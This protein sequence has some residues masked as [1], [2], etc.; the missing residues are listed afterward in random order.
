MEI[1]A[2]FLGPMSA[3]WKSSLEYPRP[4]KTHRDTLSPGI[5]G[6]R[7]WILPYLGIFPSSREHSATLDRPR[8]PKS[9]QHFYGFVFFFFQDGYCEKSGRARCP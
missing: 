9:L 4:P 8:T 3:G 5:V 1:N 2:P 6:W 7:C